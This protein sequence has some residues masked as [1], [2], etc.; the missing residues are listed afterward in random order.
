[1]AGQ[2]KIHNGTATLLFPLACT[3]VFL[4]YDFRRL[5]SFEF[6]DTAYTNTV[7]QL[8]NFVFL[9]TSVFSYA[10]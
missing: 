7:G 6:L 5:P 1:M 9:V 2:Q 3:K 10:Y 8:W 4:P